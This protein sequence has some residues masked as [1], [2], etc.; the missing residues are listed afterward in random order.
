MSLTLTFLSQ[1]RKVTNTLFPI[2]SSDYIPA[3]QD[4]HQFKSD[5]A[6]IEPTLR[7]QVR[8]NKRIPI[9]QGLFL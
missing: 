6:N 5:L 4:G 3:L 1:Y 8:Q 9:H 7:N 2:Y